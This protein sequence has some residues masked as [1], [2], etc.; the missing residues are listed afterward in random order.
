[1]PHGRSIDL[2]NKFW[3]PVRNF[4]VLKVKDPRQ[5]PFV[6][7]LAAQKVIVMYKDLLDPAVAGTLVMETAI[8]M[9][10]IDPTRVHYAYFQAY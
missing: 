2:L 8:A 4:L 3:N 6:I 1:M 10:I 7:A 5:W 9:A